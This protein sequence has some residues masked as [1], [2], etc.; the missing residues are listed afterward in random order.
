MARA[1]VSLAQA[2]KFL[3]VLTDLHGSDT[4]LEE[5]SINMH[6]EMHPNMI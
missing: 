3:V 2:L 4:F 5:I 1:M 6:V